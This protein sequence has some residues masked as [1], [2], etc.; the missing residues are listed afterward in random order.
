[1][2]GHGCLPDLVLDPD[3]D[4]DWPCPELGA[5][6]VPLGPVVPVVPLEP[7]VPVV[8]AVPLGAAAAPA[9]P[10]TAPPVAS[11]PATIVAPNSLDTFIRTTSLVFETRGLHVQVIV[12]P[13]VKPSPRNV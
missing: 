5:A 9:I 2:P 8:P 6:W 12:K 13:T 7:V 10:A 11:A 3:P 1:M 4:P